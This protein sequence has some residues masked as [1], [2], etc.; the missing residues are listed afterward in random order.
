MGKFFTDN[1]IN[2]KEKEIEGLRKLIAEKEKEVE[3]RRE[4]LLRELMREDKA[5]AENGFDEEEGNATV[6]CGYKTLDG[7][8]MPKGY[9]DKPTVM[10]F[11]NEKGE[12]DKWEGDDVSV[13]YTSDAGTYDVIMCCAMTLV[14][15]T[16]Q[17][18]NDEASNERER[19][20]FEEFASHVDVS[21]AATSVVSA[22]TDSLLDSA[23]NMLLEKLAM[24]LEEGLKDE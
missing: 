3:E 23:G 20:Q 8:P 19:K 9:L 10:M 6:T 18:L 21:K 11:F 22:T 13:M 14:K 1:E 24:I 12:D 16:L 5:A 7:K 17:A 4:R 2:K 15:A